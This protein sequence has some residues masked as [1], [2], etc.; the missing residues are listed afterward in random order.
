MAFEDHIFVSIYGNSMAYIW[1]HL[2]HTLQHSTHTQGMLSV[3]LHAIRTQ[4]VPGCFPD[5]HGP[6]HQ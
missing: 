1:T 5:V 2:H 3:P 6:D 4:D